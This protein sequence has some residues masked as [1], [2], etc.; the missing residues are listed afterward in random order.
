MATTAAEFVVAD[1]GAE[2]EARDDRL[3]ARNGSVS[4]TTAVH[5]RTALT[6]RIEMAP[7]SSMR[8]RGRS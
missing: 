7:R 5:K 3:L 2:K 1:D 6:A 4:L 8:R